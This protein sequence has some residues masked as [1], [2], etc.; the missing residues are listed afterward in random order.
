MKDAS[1]LF[2]NHILGPSIHPSFAINEMAFDRSFRYA[3]VR[4]RQDSEKRG[5]TIVLKKVKNKWTFDH[6][7]DW[8]VSS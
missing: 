6:L 3:V 1:S 2:C 4:Y 5:G 7:Y 8:W